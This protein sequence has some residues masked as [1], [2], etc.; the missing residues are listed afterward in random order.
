MR[1]LGV[2]YVRSRTGD[3]DDGCGGG[4]ADGRAMGGQRMSSCSMARM[5]RARRHARIC[6]SAATFLL[7]WLMPAVYAHPR[8]EA[9]TAMSMTCLSRDGKHSSSRMV[10][11]ES[12]R[13]R[14]RACPDC[15]SSSAG[16]AVW[17]SPLRTPCPTA[18]HIQPPLPLPQLA[19]P[20]NSQLNS[21]GTNHTATRSRGGRARPGCRPPPATPARASDIH[22]YPLTSH[23]WAAPPHRRTFHCCSP[24]VSPRRWHAGD[25]RS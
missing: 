12:H 5:Y 10:S 2:E 8:A 11:V 4:C 6:S 25:A 21:P 23:G 18:A 13:W 17:R 9:S 14:E 22:L 3:G 15:C 16:R 19:S 7:S 20:L 1:H 24:R